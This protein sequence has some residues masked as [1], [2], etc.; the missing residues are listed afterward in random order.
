M[1]LWEPAKNM[2][3]TI[4]NASGDGQS[5]FKVVKVEII[6][7]RR[8]LWG[9]RTG[10]WLVTGGFVESPTSYKGDSSRKRVK[11]LIQSGWYLPSLVEHEIRIVQPISEKTETRQIDRHGLP[12]AIGSI[13]SAEFKGQ[14]TDLSN[15]C[16]STIPL[17]IPSPLHPDD[18]NVVHGP[19]HLQLSLAVFEYPESGH[20]IPE[21]KPTPVHQL[22]GVHQS[23]IATLHTLAMI[24]IHYRDSIQA[25][26]YKRKIS[27]RGAF[28]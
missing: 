20:V 16:T 19:I 23:I 10:I 21:D 28:L 4:K 15:R 17:P 5:L 27:L 24:N 2:V 26:S 14:S 12:T 3:L 11:L 7:A 22:L 8:E 9:R 18:Q 6:E 13:V 1:D 25:T